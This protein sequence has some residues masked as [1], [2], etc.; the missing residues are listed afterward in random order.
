M[1]RSSHLGLHM[2]ICPRS[3]VRVAF[4]LHSISELGSLGDIMCFRVLGQVIVVLCS[5]TAIKELLEKRGE[6]YS[7]RPRIPIFEM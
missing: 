1:S 3:T 2:Q 6:S 7:D 5:S 4:L